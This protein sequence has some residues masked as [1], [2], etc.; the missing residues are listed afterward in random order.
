MLL[1]VV[2]VLARER[3][4]VAGAPQPAVAEEVEESLLRVIAE[5]IAEFIEVKV[6]RYIEEVLEKLHLRPSRRDDESSF[7]NSPEMSQLAAGMSEY[8]GNVVS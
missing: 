5:K 2:T 6:N 4:G 1:V 8:F 3:S 7:E